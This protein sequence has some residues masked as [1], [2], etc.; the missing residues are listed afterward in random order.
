MAASQLT[1][2]NFVF[3]GS[4]ANTGARLGTD[5]GTTSLSAFWSR[6]MMLH[7][8][9]DTLLQDSPLGQSSGDPLG[10]WVSTLQVSIVIA[11][12]SPQNRKFAGLSYSTGDSVVGPSVGCGTGIVVGTRSSS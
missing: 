10:Q 8:S 7:R 5:V 6:S 11:H 1:P 12:V 3:D 9:G 2:Q 4:P